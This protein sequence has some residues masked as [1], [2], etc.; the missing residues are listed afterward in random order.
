MIK[1]NF[2][3][4]L[5]DEEMFFLSSHLCVSNLNF[6][7]HILIPG[8]AAPHRTSVQKVKVNLKL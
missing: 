8:N 7:N 2:C 5:V 6:K 1:S 4:F 3:D